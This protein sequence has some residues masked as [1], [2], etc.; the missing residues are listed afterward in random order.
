[1][2]DILLISPPFSD[3][4]KKKGIPLRMPHLQI[5]PPLG[6]LYIASSLKEAGFRVKV[7]DME[8]DKI[9]L[10][11]LNHFIRKLHPP[12]IGI[13]CTSPLYP[14]VQQMTRIIK[15]KDPNIFVVVGGPHPTIDP[16]SVL[17]EPSIDFLIRGEG[18]ITLSELMEATIDST[19]KLADIKGLSYKKDGHQIHNIDRPLIKDLDTLSFPDRRML[20]YKKYFAASAKRNPCTSIITSR[21]CPYRC[22]F[23]SNIYHKPRFRSPQNV[24]DE[25]EM[26]ID[27]LH[28][29]DI[30]FLD[31]TFNLKKQL[32]LDICNEIIKRK[33]DFFWRC[34]CR[35]DLIDRE[36]LRHL[37]SAGC[38]LITY[39]VESGSDRI[40]KILKKGIS[41]SQV[42]YAFKI[43][44]EIGVETHG[45]FMV[46]IPGET[47][48]EIKE[49]INFS[50]KLK[51]DYA[52]FFITTPLPGSKL[53]ELAIKNKWIND[54]KE[55][56]YYDF[57]GVQKPLMKFPSLTQN[58]IN[59]LHKRAIQHFFFRFRYILMFLAKIMR[60]PRR[61]IKN[62]FLT[63]K[64][65]I[66]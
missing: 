31:S 48:Q 18:E 3:Y 55:I 24:V 20:P 51:P 21:G 6:L 11:S 13:G 9:G 63:I 27:Q 4:S 17:K 44:K 19:K 43:T 39:G 56:D 59:N 35:V 37:K 33:L 45:L 52:Q 58:E 42:K 16:H 7:I 30:E 66:E 40:L 23:C 22:I 53:L 61:F 62:I 29:R 49:T 57:L 28:I 65:L 8:V 54:I 38:Y 46:G 32:V 60:E 2:I 36:I 25:I 12:M 26:I 64:Y 47:Q 14:I 50:K 1:M 10:S 34:I 5:I 41:T 15:R